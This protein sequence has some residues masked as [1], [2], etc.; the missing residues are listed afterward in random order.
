MSVT[1][2]AHRNHVWVSLSS[3]PLPALVKLAPAKKLPKE[4]FPFPPWPPDTAS[5]SSSD[6][7]IGSLRIISG[8]VSF[9][10]VWAFQ[11]KHR[12][13][14]IWLSSRDRL[15]KLKLNAEN[16]QKKFSLIAYQ[17]LSLVFRLVWLCHKCNPDY[18]PAKRM[19]GYLLLVIQS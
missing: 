2:E 18:S 3:P 6:S 13:L 8:I 7:S 14:T 15:Q 10:L 19:K 17:M 9:H 5:S 12:P 4:K 1:F 11:S 16:R